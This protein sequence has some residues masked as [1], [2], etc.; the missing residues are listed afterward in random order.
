MKSNY[1]E[2]A[3][4]TARLAEKQEVLRAGA[5]CLVCRSWKEPCAACKAWNGNGTGRISGMRKFA[6]AFV[7]LAAAAAQTHVDQAAIAALAKEE[8]AATH[9]PGAAIGIV[10][11]NRLAY[12]F[13]VGASNV[14]TGAPVEPEMLF[15][16]GSTTKMMTATAV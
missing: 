10:I 16:L 12:A 4:R 14:E 8:L 3:L 7:L 6:L 9:T 2:K 5:Q 15:R 13:G 11:E 1:E